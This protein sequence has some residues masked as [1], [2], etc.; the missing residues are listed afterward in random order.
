MAA[1][2]EEWQEMLDKI[3][4]HFAGDDRYGRGKL[5]EIY[6]REERYDSAVREVLAQ[7]NIHSLRAY[8]KELANLYPKDYFTAY[9]ELIFPF[10]ECRMGR[11]HYQDVATILMDMKGIEGFQSEVLKIVERLRRENKRKPA[12]ID[13]LKAL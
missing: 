10:A 11:E 7:R 9:K 1:T 2:K 5:I 3:L 12:F 4:V 8:H 13:E 6:I